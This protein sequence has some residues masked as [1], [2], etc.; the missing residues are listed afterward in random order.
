MMWKYTFL[1]IKPYFLCEYIGFEVLEEGIKVV[2][3]RF[4]GRW[5]NKKKQK[6]GLKLVLAD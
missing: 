4:F 5:H 1:T 3:V 2:L 6:G